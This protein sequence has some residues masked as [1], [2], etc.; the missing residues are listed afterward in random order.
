MA[1]LITPDGVK[2]P[3]AQGRVTLGREAS[4]INIPDAQASRRHAQIARQG[5]R[6]TIS[7]LGSTNGTFVNGVQVQGAHPLQTGDR[8]RIG[9]SVLVFAEGQVPPGTRMIS[10]DSLPPAPGTS[11]SRPQS[12]AARPPAQGQSSQPS[13]RPPAQW[14]AAPPSQQQSAA[15]WQAPAPG[16]AY[17]N[18]PPKQRS[19]AML[20]EIIGGFFGLLGLGWIYADRS[21]VG[22]PALIVGLLLN[23]TYCVIG[24]FTMGFSLIITIPLQIITIVVSALLLNTYTKQRIDLFGP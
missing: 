22:V 20:L 7:D 21:G 9:T 17:A 23:I 13:A 3:L 15:Q 16:G 4:D 24:T 10:S 18:R 2:Y 6:W 1:N 14:Q 12:V 19:T 5:D 8:I 11:A